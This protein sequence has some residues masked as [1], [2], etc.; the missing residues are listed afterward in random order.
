MASVNFHKVT[1]LPGTLS[2]DAVYYLTGSAGVAEEF[3]TSTTGAS[4]QVAPVGTVAPPV[5]SAATSTAGTS[6]VRA[7]ADHTHGIST[8]PSTVVATTQTAGDSSTKVATTAFVGTA[9]T[10]AAGSY[11]KLASANV[12]TS[13]NRFSAVLDAAGSSGTIGQVLASDGSV[14][15]WTT[16]PAPGTQWLTTAW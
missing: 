12:W 6:D 3:V 15:T 4:R 1:T 16:L 11:G 14:C 7:R 9:I 8:L 5:V 10:G 13:S 2:S